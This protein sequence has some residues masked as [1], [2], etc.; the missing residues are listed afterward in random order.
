MQRA[1]RSVNKEQPHAALLLNRG[2]KNHLGL[3][4]YTAPA[5][6][7]PH[8]LTW[9]YDRGVSHPRV[10]AAPVSSFAGPLGAVLW[11]IS[12]PVSSLLSQGRCDIADSRA[13]LRQTMFSMLLVSLPGT[14]VRRPRRPAPRGSNLQRDYKEKAGRLQAAIIEDDG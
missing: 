8:G 5:G 2:Y 10:H 7:I 3:L 4:R 9:V 12:K 14:W 6:L 11:H 1:Q 13:L